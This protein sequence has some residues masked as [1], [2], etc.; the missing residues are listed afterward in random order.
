M[1]LGWKFPAHIFDLQGVVPN[2]ERWCLA[3]F[4]APHADGARRH[5]AQEQRLV[6]L[7][8]Q[9]KPK[10][11]DAFTEPKWPTQTLQELIWHSFAGRIIDREDHPGLLRLI[12]ARQTS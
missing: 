10:D 7:H 1:G 2:I 3:E 8:C 5:L 6:G 12:G 11:Q 4:T 9:R